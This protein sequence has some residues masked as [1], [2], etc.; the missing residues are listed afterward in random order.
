MVAAGVNPRAQHRMR[1][2]A[3][4]LSVFW[5]VTALGAFLLLAKSTQN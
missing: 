3:V 2:N 4:A 5:G 1:L